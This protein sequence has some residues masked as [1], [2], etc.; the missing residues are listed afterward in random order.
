MGQKSV[1][2]EDISANLHRHSNGIWYCLNS[3]AISYPVQGNSS[4]YQVEDSSFWFTHRNN[5]ILKL[6]EH[7]PP[8]GTLFDVGGGNGFVSLA[9][10]EAG[11]DVVLVEPGTEGANNAQERGI[12]EVVC[13]ALQDAEFQPSSLPAVGIFDVLEHIEDHQHFLSDIHHLLRPAGMLYITV[14]AYQWLWSQDDV[15]AGHF[16]RYT[17]RSLRKLL[18]E[19]GYDVISSTYI[20]WFLPFPVFLRRTIPS[21]LKLRQTGVLAQTKK[22][23]SKPGGIAGS[24]LNFFLNCELALLEQG[25]RIPFGGSCLIAA[26]KG[27]SR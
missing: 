5:C 10:Q 20:F 16:R 7:V 12:N 26:Q 19:S 18:K 25:F 27:E 21:L 17:T 24:A 4:C 1:S 23:H 2:I 13:A 3:S 6:L 22:E 9:M 11:R 8:P 14:P 15:H